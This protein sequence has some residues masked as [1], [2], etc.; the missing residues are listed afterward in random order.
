MGIKSEYVDDFFK[1][2]YGAEVGMGR[3]DSDRNYEITRMKKILENKAM[4]E[5]I[6]R[7]YEAEYE[8]AKATRDMLISLNIKNPDTGR[9]MRVPTPSWM[10]YYEK[11]IAPQMPAKAA[12]VKKEETSFLKRL[13]K[14]GS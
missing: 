5:D 13:F 10:R 6:V 7:K 4:T 11:N 12:P 1:L 8:K 14:Y 2:Y 3:A 9:P